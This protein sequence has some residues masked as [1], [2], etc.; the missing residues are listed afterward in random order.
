MK[1]VVGRLNLLEAVGRREWAGEQCKQNNAACYSCAVTEPLACPL[2]AVITLYFG[3]ES[4]AVAQSPMRQR[5]IKRIT[6]GNVLVEKKK[7]KDK[8]IYS[9]E[10]KKSREPFN[11]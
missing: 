9:V 4:A 11:A 2:H 10:C 3:Y 6:L 1:V 7:W 8:A 5:H